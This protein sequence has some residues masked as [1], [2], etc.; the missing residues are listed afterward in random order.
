MRRLF[1]SALPSKLLDDIRASYW[2]VPSAMALLAVLG[3]IG[4]ESVDRRGW[5]EAIPEIF[6]ST[7]ADAARAVLSVIASAAIGTAGVMF[8]MTIV[9][10]SF[11][12]TNFGPRLIGNFMRDRGVQ[13]SLGMLLATFVFA[14]MIQR[15]IR[16]GEDGFDFLPALSMT[17]ALAL[18]LVSVG[19]MIYFVHHIPERLSLEN[20]TA[21]LGRTLLAAASSMP[22]SQAGPATDEEDRP[23]PDALPIALETTGFIHAVD[24]EALQD[25]M[26]R[27]RLSLIIR[28]WPGDFAAPHK[29][30]VL[31]QN[32]DL[33]DADRAEIRSCFAVGIGRTEA[34]NP[35]FLAQQLAEIVA[36]ALSP[37][38]NDP[39]TAITCLNWLD[40]ALHALADRGPVNPTP[41]EGG[42]VLSFAGL[43]DV[44]Y[45]FLR[46]YIAT[47]PGVTLHALS[48][49][50][51]LVAALPEGPRKDLAEAARA[52]VRAEA[53]ARSGETPE[54]AALARA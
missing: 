20:V 30:V 53:R 37:G 51:T 49:L 54:I 34:Q 1:K 33:S 28:M 23:D 27:R 21:R 29:P 52:D 17:V 14:L 15:G 18:A 48:L 41:G 43:L 44:S 25:L 7:Q 45:R 10:V 39:V 19:V 2:F 4:A 26:G 40:A 24:G 5:S 9:A 8:S 36:R 32:G 12:S 3:A 6:Y 47:D 38:V 16:S 42:P 46:P 31:V 50:D 13:V 11:A 35:T 22:R